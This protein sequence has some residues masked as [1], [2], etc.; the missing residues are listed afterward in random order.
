MLAGVAAGGGR[1]TQLP[2]N[3]RFQFASLLEGEWVGRSCG[4]QKERGNKKQV[5][6]VRGASVY[7]ERK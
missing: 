5:G 4:T 6:G 2:G 1:P 3:F 7:A